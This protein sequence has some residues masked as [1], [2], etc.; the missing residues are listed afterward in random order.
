[1][2]VIRLTFQVGW[3]AELSRHFHGNFTKLLHGK[4]TKLRARS[5][6]LRLYL[7]KLHRPAWSG[8]ALY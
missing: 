1:M 2:A 6:T 7:L 4:L 5:V 3:E 8:A